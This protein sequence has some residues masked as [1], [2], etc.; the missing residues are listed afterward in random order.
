MD[1]DYLSAHE[2]WNKIEILQSTVSQMNNELLN[3]VWYDSL[4]N[5]IDNVT[6]L[7]KK[8]DHCQIDINA[9][10]DAIFESHNMMQRRVMMIPIDNV[11]V[12]NAEIQS[13]KLIIRRIELHQTS[14]FNVLSDIRDLQRE[15]SKLR[16]DINKNNFPKEEI[17][18][19]E[20]NTDKVNHEIMERIEKLENGLKDVDL[21]F[22]VNEERIRNAFT[23]LDNNKQLH[24]KAID[25]DYSKVAEFTSTKGTKATRR[26]NKRINHDNIN[27]DETSDENQNNDLS[28]KFVS[29]IDYEFASSATK[30]K[31]TSLTIKTNRIEKKIAIKKAFKLFCKLLQEK[32]YQMKLNS[33]QYWSLLTRHHLEELRQLR[34]EKGTIVVLKL[35]P[36][37]ERNMIK[38][39]YRLF[40]NWKDKIKLMKKGQIMRWKCKEII[41]KWMSVTLPTDIRYYLR[42]WRRNIRLITTFLNIQNNQ[43]IKHNKK[44]L[45]NKLKNKHLNENNENEMNE[46]TTEQ[47]KEISIIN[48][49]INL[50]DN[51]NHDLN[52]SGMSILQRFSQL[53]DDPTVQIF[54][55]GKSSYELQF[56]S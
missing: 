47:L 24:L 48:D 7:S 44:N 53:S 25:V 56:I 27:D 49:I 11:K 21:R 2:I 4:Q 18:N 46:Q 12:I 31:L 6:N 37:Y 32:Y 19:Q 14:E 10:R 15:V 36:I 8:I 23:D 9:I 5:K 20:M 16:H 52:D 26:V 3:P 51:N 29:L 33:F 17:I 22:E 30:G 38:K 28:S 55:L 41:S 39:L 43:K 54:F 13:L 34:H 42:K 1:Y 45:K 50:V 40:S 35:Y